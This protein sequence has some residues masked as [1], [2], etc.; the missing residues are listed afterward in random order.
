MMQFENG[1][2]TINVLL[3]DDKTEN[4]ISLEG[5]LESPDIKFIRATSG[6]EALEAALETLPALILLD[7]QMPGMNGFEVARALKGMK[8]T[9]Y[10]PIIFVTATHREEK[11][12]FEGFETGAVDYLFKP[13][14][15]VVVRSKVRVFVELH[16]KSV[17]LE[18]AVRDLSLINHELESFSYSVSHDLRAPVRSI[19]G[20]SKFAL[21]KMS[22]PKEVEAAR[23]DLQ[24]VVD[25]GEKMNRLIE[26]LLDLARISQSELVRKDLSLSDMVQEIG[27]EMNLEARER[28]VNLKIADSVKVSGDKR[29]IEV[30]L[31]NLLGNA[32]KFTSKTPSPQIEFGVQNSSE[33]VYFIRDNG[34]G[35]DMA[36]AERLFGAFQ[37]LHSAEE[38]SG[39]G[40]GLAT[41]QRIIHRHGGK[42]WAESSPGEGATFYFSL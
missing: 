15:P 23:A 5:V 12:S 36:Y 18:R 37:R 33:P 17:R 20:F 4:L 32:F 14:N 6:E 27:S 35:F 10:I 39:T 16:G 38:F 13:L 24:R 7:V 21:E 25:S 9:R 2:E 42:I 41:V 22:N 1:Q 28:E 31:R 8:R 19:I 34:A 11:F 3:V 30:V 40:V 26:A 29:L